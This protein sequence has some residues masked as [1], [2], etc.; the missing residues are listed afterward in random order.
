ML[1]YQQSVCNILNH[2]TIYQILPSICNNY[3]IRLPTFYLPLIKHA[4]AQQRLDYQL[5]RMLN[6]YGSVT[7]TLKAQSLFFYGFK[8]FVKVQLINGYADGCHDTS[9]ITL[10]YNCTSS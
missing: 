7:F 3:S 9:C 2:Y 5:I 1:D 6:A 8:T 10:S 4:F